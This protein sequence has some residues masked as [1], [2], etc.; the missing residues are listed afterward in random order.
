MSTASVSVAVWLSARDNML[1][2]MFTVVLCTVVVVPCTTRLPVSDKSLAPMSAAVDIVTPPI[3][4]EAALNGGKECML[5][6]IKAFKER[7][8]FVLEKLNDIDGFRCIPAEGAFYTFID[9]KK[10]INNLFDSKKIK[11]ASDLSFTEYLIESQGVAVVPGSAFG[12]SGYF[13]I[14]FAT[15]ME[16]LA[17][18]MKRIK[19]AVEG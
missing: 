11:E 18:S 13:R 1:S 15:S 5:P 2:L 17:E 12:L 16:N 7:H 3:A 4:A 8:D 19:Q 9:A 10:A 14:S 6:M